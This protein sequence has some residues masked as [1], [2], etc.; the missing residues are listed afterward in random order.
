MSLKTVSVQI[1]VATVRI[2]FHDLT[3]RKICAKSVPGVINDDQKEDSLLTAARW[4]MILRIYSQLPYRPDP[5][6]S[7]F[8]LFLNLNKG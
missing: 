2:I 4:L 7:D 8:L 5:S 1:G 6:A 3:M